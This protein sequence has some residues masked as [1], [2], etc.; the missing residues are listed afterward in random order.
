MLREMRGKTFLLMC[1]LGKRHK[2]WWK[3]FFLGKKINHVQQQQQQPKKV[4][5][6]NISTAK[7]SIL[8]L[9]TPPRFRQMY[10][11]LVLYDKSYFSTVYVH[12]KTYEEYRSAKWCK[13]IVY[14]IKKRRVE[15][16]KKLI[17]SF[18][19]QKCH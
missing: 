14:I 4:C 13:F 15:N 19:T 17:R 7:K 1:R 8:L 2:F 5:C 10:F 3:F 16:K 9:F 6:I 18:S 11:F 12:T